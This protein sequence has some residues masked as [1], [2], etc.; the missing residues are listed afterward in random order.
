MEQQISEENVDPINLL[1]LQV[2]ALQQM[3]GKKEY[4][5]VNQFLEEASRTNPESISNEI[6]EKSESLLY[7]RLIELLNAGL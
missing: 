1:T 7:G 5:V 6:L 3:E 2:S 4:S